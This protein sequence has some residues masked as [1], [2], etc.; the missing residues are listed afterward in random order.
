M[1]LSLV[2]LDITNIEEMELGLRM[3]AGTLTSN[4][5]RKDC[6]LKEIKHQQLQRT[7]VSLTISKNT[8]GELLTIHYPCGNEKKSFQAGELRYVHDRAPVLLLL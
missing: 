5:D 1:A 8:T 4:K 6:L 7:T 2:E 3:T